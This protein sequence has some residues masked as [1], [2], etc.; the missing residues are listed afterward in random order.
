MNGFRT[1]LLLSDTMALMQCA[2]HTSSGKTAALAWAMGRL[3]RPGIRIKLHETPLG[4]VL[5]AEVGPKTGPVLAW[6]GHLDVVVGDCTPRI[7]GNILRGR[8]GA[9][10]HGGIAA[11]IHALEALANQSQVRVRLVL[12]CD[13]EDLPPHSIEHYLRA[14][15]VDFAVALEPTANKVSLQ[16]MGATWLNVTVSGVRAHS[17]RPHLGANAIE[18]ATR[19]YEAIKSLPFGGVSSEWFPGGPAIAITK[20]EAGVTLSMVPDICRMTISV[21]YLPGQTVADIVRQIHEAAEALRRQVPGFRGMEVTVEWSPS[22]PPAAV[23]PDNPYVVALRQ[24]LIARGRRA[25]EVFTAREGTSDA[26]FANGVEFG[27]DGAGHHGDDEHVVIS[28]I[29]DTADCL[30]QSALQS[31]RAE[32]E[33]A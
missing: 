5:A 29:V 27:P 33:V 26:A 24:A 16:S 31:P 12:V 22:F 21:R 23:A 2:P 8:G 28:S 11:G 10:M 1:K 32:G 3:D 20:I 15:A 18:R 4:R 25:D 14:N 17:A 9:D 13:E 30:Y 7:E 19:L 6:L